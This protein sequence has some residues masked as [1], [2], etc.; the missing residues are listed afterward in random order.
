MFFNQ[1]INLPPYVLSDILNQIHPNCGMGL[2][3][4]ILAHNE[5][6]MR[7]ECGIFPTKIIFRK[8]T[9]ILS[10]GVLHIIIKSNWIYN[11]TNFLT[12]LDFRG[13]HVGSKNI[14]SDIP[15]LH[16]N[17]SGIKQ[18]GI[19]KYMSKNT[20]TKLIN[21]C[22]NTQELYHD[23][24]LEHVF[25]AKNLDIFTITKNLICNG[26]KLYRLDARL[27]FDKMSLIPPFLG[28]L[29]TRTKNFGISLEVI[30][31][32]MLNLNN[33]VFTGNIF[34]EMYHFRKII[35]QS[36]A[37]KKILCTDEN[38]SYSIADAK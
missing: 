37:T 31:L 13:L 5:E 33:A 8:A 3:N 23:H 38:F 19:S 1:I 17:L 14:I 29:A 15:A 21:N 26:G 10:N 9:S 22:P 35:I 11:F 2:L 20:A 6:T 12:I 28:A 18:L 16:I 34:S 7:E 24:G 27:C 30:D 4:I 25:K 36:D 32:R